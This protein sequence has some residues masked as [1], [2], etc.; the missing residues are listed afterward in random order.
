MTTTTTNKRV[1]YSKVKLLDNDTNFN[2]F[3]ENFKI[4]DDEWEETTNDKLTKE[5]PVFNTKSIKLKEIT[6]KLED[7][8]LEDRISKSD[9]DFALRRVKKL[10]Q[11]LGLR[12][13]PLKV[14][15]RKNGVTASGLPNECH[16]NVT[17]MVDN[18]GGNQVIGYML[19]KHDGEIHLS[20]HSVWETPEGKLA[21]VTAK[22]YGS[23][24]TYFYPL[25]TFDPA[26]EKYFPRV[27]FEIKKNIHEGV[28]IKSAIGHE[29]DNQ[30]VPLNFFKKVS[31]ER[32]Q[33]LTLLHTKKVSMN[34][35]TT[36]AWYL[37][38][39][40]HLQKRLESEVA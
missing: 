40:R 28:A 23:D 30:I 12:E 22:G 13:T 20:H 27:Q 24:Y 1:N 21:D 9:L 15:V 16:G 7:I 32:I 34:A 17:F 35:D 19:T 3:K 37:E 4:T 25:K 26:V 33:K 39:L 29:K 18:Y 31:K 10:T 14:K 11:A 5:N 6:N 38:R 8:I 36:Y 2:K